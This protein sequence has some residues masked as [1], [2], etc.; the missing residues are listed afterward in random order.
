MKL[1]SKEITSRDFLLMTLSGILLAVGT[2]LFKYPNN[3][4]LGGVTGISIVLSKLMNVSASTIN[5]VV[6]VALMIVGVLILGK[7]FAGKTIY[8]CS[9]FTVLLSVLDTYFPI[10]APLTTQPLMELFFAV[11][12]SGIASAILFNMDASSGGTDII[13]MIIKRYTNA[14]IGTA[15]LVVDFLITISTFFVFNIETGLLSLTGL[16]IKTLILDSAIENIN[17]CKYIT[18]ITVSPEPICD[19]IHN[20][21]HRSATAYKAEGTY[22]HTEKTVIM[23]VMK[24]QQAVKLRL[25]VKG[26]DP[27]AFIMITNSSEIIGK[28]FRGFN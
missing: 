6:N 5:L 3:F 8:V 18:I 23:T 16:L 20:E 26:A 28:G 9:L 13:A 25:F 11:G 2:W 22:T 27:N 1:F 4:S 7:E 24:R 12:F 14:E 19:F 17:L 15:L 21:L 10:K